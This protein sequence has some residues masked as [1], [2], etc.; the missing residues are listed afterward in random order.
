MVEKC[1]DALSCANQVPHT[2]LI[3]LMWGP[4]EIHVHL[5]F[6]TQSSYA[7]SQ[8]AVM[9]SVFQLLNNLSG[10]TQL[11]HSRQKLLNA[12]I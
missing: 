5:M 2:Q 10:F 9:G 1:S 12:T 3:L 4:M 11:N 8:R 7:W 6:A